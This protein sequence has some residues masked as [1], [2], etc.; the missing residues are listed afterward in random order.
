MYWAFFPP[1]LWNCSL[2]VNFSGIVAHFKLLSI[3][4]V[5]AF[6][7]GLRDRSVNQRDWI[8]YYFFKRGMPVRWKGSKVIIASAGSLFWNFSD[9]TYVGHS[10][11]VYSFLY[12]T[13]HTS[14]LHLIV[15]TVPKLFNSIFMTI[16][17]F[18]Y[19][20]CKDHFKWH[21][22]GWSYQSTYVRKVENT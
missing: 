7:S 6:L 21:A 19:S 17:V 1:C 11:Q 22:Y 4:S 9:N 18:L 13:F 8:Y 12:I 3:L 16:Y 10:S 5:S 15:T 14:I 20:P 2:L